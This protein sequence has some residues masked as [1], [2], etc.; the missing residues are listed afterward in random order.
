MAD[1][2][3]TVGLPG[4]SKMRS[5]RKFA[6]ITLEK[7]TKRDGVYPRDAFTAASCLL[8]HRPL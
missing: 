1:C 2:D 8:R 4:I 6:R 5:K 3:G 7:R